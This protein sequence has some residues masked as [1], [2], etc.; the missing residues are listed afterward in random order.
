MHLRAKE[1][2]AMQHVRLVYNYLLFLLIITFS[3]VNIICF[4][5]KVLKT[6]YRFDSQLTFIYFFKKKT[7]KR[8]T[9]I[10]YEQ[11]HTKTEKKYDYII[12]GNDDKY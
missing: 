9:L 2:D 10:G 8:I 3:L 1:F 6:S 5:E 11:K 4:F 7:T 12:I